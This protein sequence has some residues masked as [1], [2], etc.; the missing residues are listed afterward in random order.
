MD[1]QAMITRDL[2]LRVCANATEFDPGWLEQDR[3]TV[4]PFTAPRDTALIAR[5]VA[6]GHALGADRL[7][8]C[9]T[10]AEFAY[11]PVTEVGPDPMSIFEVIRSWGDEPTDLL[12]TVEDLSAAVLIA[13]SALTVAAG[14]PDFLRPLV[15]P[16][17]AEAR[18]RFGEEARDDRDPDLLRAAQRYG[19][20][21]QGARHARGPRGPGPDPAER[22]AARV[23]AARERSPGT[24]AAFRGL[25]GAWSWAMLALLLTAPLFLP[26]LSPVP[27][28]VLGVLWLLVQLAWLS[29]S[30]TVGFATL[31][32]V[33]LLGALMLWPIALAERA[34]AGATGLDPQGWAAY[35]YLAVPVEEV[36]KLVPL[37]LLRL[38]ARR[39]FRRFAAVD[40]LL[41]A[42][43]SGAGF[44]LAEEVLR[45][46]SSTAGG[47]LAVPRFGLFTLFPGA[48]EL[49]EA[50]VHFS[51][52]GVTTALIG[53]AF[54]L[55]VVGARRYGAWL[56][57]LPVVAVW[58]AGLEH[59]VF[60]A[61]VAGIE[62]TQATR[63]L[64]T[65]SGG[66][67]ATRWF[68][69]VLL[70]AAVLLDYRLAR[71]GTDGAPPLPGDPPLA[72]LRRWTPAPTAPRQ[73]GA[74]PG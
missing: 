40:Y 63:V 27:G 20:L 3:K 51:G 32:R 1:E 47:A 2:V 74:G 69:L 57:L 68:L 12:V 42:A 44:Q 13:S 54:G 61:A 28:V 60:N 36:G 7:L 64:Y 29:R 39:R 62:P 46:V 59:M 48:V 10:R 70:V 50:G 26:G 43:A 23:R 24:V 72:G 37:L 33:L 65:L 38:V 31:V 45:A 6:A 73:R 25:R 55:A 35:T 58:V 21:E 49:P 16:D 30:R 52:H 66:G 17:P 5:V 11:E 9:R 34:L 67:A 71:P 18:T 15:G 22:V 8:V 4:V 56:W 41:L 14:P 53:A 19:C